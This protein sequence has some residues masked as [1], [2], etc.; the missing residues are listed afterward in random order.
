[1]LVA[2]LC[3]GYLHPEFYQRATEAQKER[4]RKLEK[5]YWE[6]ALACWG[7]KSSGKFLFVSLRVYSTICSSSEVQLKDEDEIS[8]CCTWTR[9][10]CRRRGC[11]LFC[12]RLGKPSLWAG[13]QGLTSVAAGM[14]FPEA[15][16]KLSTH[17]FGQLERKPTWIAVKSGS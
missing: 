11:H 5:T 10:R 4:L 17:C 2:M 13:V 14:R 8:P 3:I 9:Q 15:S 7:L 16:A 12:Q 1:M 6:R